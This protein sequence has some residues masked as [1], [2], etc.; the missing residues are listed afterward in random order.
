MIIGE[1]DI[2]VLKGELKPRI[3]FT[4][5]SLKHCICVVNLDDLKELNDKVAAANKDKCDAQAELMKAQATD[6]SRQVGS[7]F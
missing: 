4:F 5:I 3:A 2:Q 7:M 6:L 1:L